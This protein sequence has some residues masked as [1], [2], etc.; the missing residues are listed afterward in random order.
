MKR[1]RPE[2]K[3]KFKDLKNGMRVIRKNYGLPVNKF[4]GD[5]HVHQEIPK[6][7]LPK[8]DHSDKFWASIEPFCANITKDD[9]AVS[10]LIV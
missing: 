3:P 1:K 6:V 7:T 8:N 5:S 9:I 4:S 10:N 2:E